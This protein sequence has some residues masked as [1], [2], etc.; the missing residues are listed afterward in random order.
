MY[1]G[2]RDHTTV[3]R[4][5]KAIEQKIEKTK[6]NQTINQITSDLAQRFLKF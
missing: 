3:M 6:V 1:F 5:I 4:T 2:G